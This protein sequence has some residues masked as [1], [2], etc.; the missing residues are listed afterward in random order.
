MDQDTGAA[1]KEPFSTLAKIRWGS[2]GGEGNGVWMHACGRQTWRA[3]SH[4]LS[5]RGSIRCRPGRATGVEFGGG[6]LH[7]GGA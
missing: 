6:C 7:A 1:G 3:G 4:A 2:G 5:I